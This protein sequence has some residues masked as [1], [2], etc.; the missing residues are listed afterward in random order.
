MTDALK[1]SRFMAK[2]VAELPQNSDPE[3]TLGSQADIRFL[4]RSEAIGK[5]LPPLE[6]KCDISSLV[7]AQ[8]VLKMFARSLNEPSAEAE[9]IRKRFDEISHLIDLANWFRRNGSSRSLGEKVSMLQTSRVFDNERLDCDPIYASVIRRHRD[10]LLEH[11][12]VKLEQAE[13]AEQHLNTLG[14]CV[15][16]KRRCYRKRA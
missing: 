2:L 3:R 16:E 12:E 15:H 11:L 9:T 14:W 6:T 10:K 8:Y 4:K 5:D 7:R 13:Q 1:R